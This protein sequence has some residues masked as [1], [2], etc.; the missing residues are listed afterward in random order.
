MKIAV[1]GAGAMGGLFGARLAQAGEDVTLVD[2]APQAVD[3]INANGVRL[4]EKSGGSQA[5]RVPAVTD[6]ADVG[7]VDLVLV[8]VKCYHTEAALRAAA[9]LLNGN[10]AVLTLQNGWG[11]A[12]RIAAIVGEARV[13]VGLTY[14][15][16]T[17][18][19]PG[20]VLHAGQGM[21]FVGEM[22]GTT[23]PRMEQI[24]AAFRGAGLEVTPT[25]DV[26]S[27]IW[28][29]LALNC[30]TLPTAALLRFYAG[31]LVEHEEMLDMMRGL[32]REV[33]AVANAQNIALSYTER[34]EA[35]TSLLRR[36]TGAKP[37][38]LQD[39]E[40]GRRTEID[41]IN[42]AIVEAGRRQH[43]PTPYNEAMVWLI[44]SLEATVERA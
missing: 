44:K 14:H 38:M 17:M 20:H 35:I 32:L 24:A 28:A 31:Q 29:K 42:G 16:A 19:G 18:L 11:N 43:I 22:N 3:A 30:C 25:A 5:I 9:P 7:P 10:T 2:V 4:D 8:F 27:Q 33:V 21:T 37:S 26:L 23:S 12:A 40:N 36:A 34:W 13:L 41:V 6:P 1:I 15:S 39:V